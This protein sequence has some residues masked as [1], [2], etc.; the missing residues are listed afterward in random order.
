MVR[1]L[2]LLKAYT[3]CLKTKVG[4]VFRAHFRGLNGQKSKTLFFRHPVDISKP[5]ISIRDIYERLRDKRP[6]PGSNFTWTLGWA[7]LGYF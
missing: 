2:K 6:C 1:W 4:L 7:G 5:C 3:W